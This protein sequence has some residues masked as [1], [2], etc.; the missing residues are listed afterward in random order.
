M[1]MLLL[2]ITEVIC[3]LGV[4][5][6][7]GER[8]DQFRRAAELQH[9]GV[10]G[11][12]VVIRHLAVLACLW[13][14]DSGHISKSQQFYLIGWDDAVLLELVASVHLEVKPD[15]QVGD[16][17]ASEQITISFSQVLVVRTVKLSPVQAQHCCN[18][19]D[20]TNGCSRIGLLECI[21]HG[22]PTLQLW[23]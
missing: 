18:L 3:R 17:M 7:V 12:L 4:A 22:V 15:P 14:V 13:S 2:W 19:D 1:R 5:A 10:L 21:G 11:V 8:F 20:M 16:L 9:P 23:L 6:E